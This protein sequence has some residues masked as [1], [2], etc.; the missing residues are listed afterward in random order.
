MAEEGECLP[1]REVYSNSQD[2]TLINT[3]TVLP[4]PFHP[5]YSSAIHFTKNALW[6]AA[7]N[8]VLKSYQE[9]QAGQPT[10][11]QGVGGWEDVHD[12]TSYGDS[13]FVLCTNFGLR[14]LKHLNIS[15]ISN[16]TQV[17]E[18]RV[19]PRYGRCLVSV[20]GVGV[21]NRT[22]GYGKATVEYIQFYLINNGKTESKKVPVPD[23]GHSRQASMC[24]MNGE[25]A[26]LVGDKKQ[27]LKFSC[28]QCDAVPTLI[29]EF[30]DEILNICTDESGDRI[31]VLTFKPIRDDEDDED[32]V[33][34]HS[35]LLVLSRAG[36]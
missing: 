2:L 8:S 4:I 26:F 22:G 32:I 27:L 5:V 16:V 10:C 18:Y 20:E 33:E 36:R 12:L 31:Y 3:I 21:G 28:L 1:K 7:G 17:D 13:L 29:Y 24:G 35:N 23:A 6:F 11:H 25:S 14:F 15:D 19:Y 34:R 30:S 9:G